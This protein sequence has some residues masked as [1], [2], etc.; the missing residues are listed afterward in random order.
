MKQ[1]FGCIM[2]FI[3]LTH[4]AFVASLCSRQSCE[5]ERNAWEAV[6]KLLTGSGFSWSLLSGS[7]QHCG[8]ELS[9]WCCHTKAQWTRFAKWKVSL[10][11]GPPCW[12]N[13]FGLPNCLWCIALTITVES[14]RAIYSHSKAA[15]THS[16]PSVHTEY[17]FIFLPTRDRAAHFA[18]QSNP[19]KLNIH[20]HTV[21]CMMTK[22]V[23]AR[24]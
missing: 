16:L 13:M 18:L 8:S 5:G 3:S 11:V 1:R 22:Q 23:E 20:T 4:W 10:P 2:T 21:Y 24:R 14:P 7:Q 6:F 15:A 19:L 17:H 9:E 12:L